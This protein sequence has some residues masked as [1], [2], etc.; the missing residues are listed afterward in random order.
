[1]SKNKTKKSLQPSRNAE[2]MRREALKHTKEKDPIEKSLKEGTGANS[3]TEKENVPTLRRSK[4][5]PPI[6]KM[7]S[8]TDSSEQQPNKSLKVKNSAAKTIKCTSTI[9]PKLEISSIKDLEPDTLS[10]ESFYFEERE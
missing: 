3:S 2:V 6:S 5:K 8:N 4:R 7:E 10:M 9:N 1:M